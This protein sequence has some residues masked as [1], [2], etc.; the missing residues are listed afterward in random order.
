MAD[1][2]GSNL[3]LMGI[4]SKKVELGKALDTH[5]MSAWMSSPQVLATISKRLPVFLKANAEKYSKQALSLFVSNPML[6]QCAPMTIVNSL[7][8]ASSLGLDLTPQLGQAYIIPYKARRKTPQGWTSVYEAQF[9]LGYKG[10]I[11]LMY[12][13]GQVANIYGYEVREGD[14]FIFRKGLNRVLEHW[15]GEDPDHTDPNREDKPITHVYAVIK[16]RTGGE[17]FDVWST[18]KLLAHALKY[19]K[20]AVKHDWNTGKDIIGPDGKPVLDEQSPW[21]TAFIPMSIKTILMS[22]RAVAPMSVELMNAFEVENHRISDEELNISVNTPA[23]ALVDDAVDI[24]PDNS[25]T[26]EIPES[27]TATT[28]G[29]KAAK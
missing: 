21:S 25:E 11:D 7:V 5:E 29:K 27:D 15:D 19:S 1:V 9:Q 10:V 12:R 17:I 14:H 16:L 4:V 24:E 8:V 3:G 20:G 28:P 13:S 18:Q 23:A 2:N 22:L 6:Q 26:I